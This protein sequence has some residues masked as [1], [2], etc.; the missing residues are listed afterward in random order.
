MDDIELTSDSDYSY[1]SERKNSKKKRSKK[2]ES[3]KSTKSKKSKKTQNK[4]S[5]LKKNVALPLNQADEDSESEIEKVIT[6]SPIKV[7]PMDRERQSEDSQIEKFSKKNDSDS[8]FPKFNNDFLLQINKDDLYKNT[9]SK[10]LKPIT[11]IKYETSCNSSLTNQFNTKHQSYVNTSSL[12]LSP[13]V[14]IIPIKPVRHYLTVE[15]PTLEPIRKKDD[16]IKEG[17]FLSHCTVFKM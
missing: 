13:A 1:G 12:I 17:T 2:K 6:L 4:K 9:D 14:N 11:P 7:N 10:L 5:L 16:N 3:K 15:Q 8:K